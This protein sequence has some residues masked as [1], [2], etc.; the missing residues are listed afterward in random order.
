MRNRNGHRAGDG[1]PARTL[2][3]SGGTKAATLIN[4]GNHPVGY[5][6]LAREAIQNEVK[7][8]NKKWDTCDSIVIWNRLIED[9][10]F[11]AVEGI[12]DVQ[13]TSI[14][15]EVSRFILGE[16]QIIGEVTVNEG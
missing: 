5:L 12:R 15:G 6:K 3:A 7:K 8:L 16:N 1:N 11:S 2:S 10:A 4:G 13:V 9:A 14:N